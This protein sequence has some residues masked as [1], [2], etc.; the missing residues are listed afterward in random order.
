M[1]PPK[2]QT[3]MSTMKVNDYKTGEIL[4]K[5]E[6]SDEQVAKYEANAQQPQGII[7]A[8]DVMSAADLDRLNVKADQTIWLD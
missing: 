8:G 4:G 2:K 3:K 5:I 6:L 1:T 7:R